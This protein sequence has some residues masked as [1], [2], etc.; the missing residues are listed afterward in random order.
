MPDL[1]TI[2]CVPV[3]FFSWGLNLRHSFLVHQVAQSGLS[4]HHHT[5]SIV[6]QDE[7]SCPG[8]PIT[9]STHSTLQYLTHVSLPLLYGESKLSLTKRILKALF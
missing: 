4:S 8:K 3:I 6:H 7:T 1:V 5:S 9:P 2:N